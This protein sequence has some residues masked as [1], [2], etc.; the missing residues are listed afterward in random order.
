[1]GLVTMNRR[2]RRIAG[3][4]LC[5]TIAAST[6]GASMAAKESSAELDKYTEEK[7]IVDCLLQGQIRK[8]GTTVYQ[9]PPRP[10]KLPARDCEIRGGDF[11]VFDRSS[12]SASLGHWLTLA[13]QGDVEA[14]IYVGEIFERGMGRE[15]DYERAAE[16][17][18]KAAES[19]HPV[20][21]ISLAQLYEKG[22][23][24]PQDA[25]EAE[26]LYRDAFGAGPTEQVALDPGSIDD[27]AERMQRLETQLA[28]A[29][30]EAAEL[31]QQ[32]AASEQRLAAAQSNLELRLTEEE[33]LQRQLADAQARVSAA[34]GGSSELAAAQQELDHRNRE[35]LN[36][37]QTI[38]SLREEID[39]NEGQIVAYQGEYA[40]ISELETRLQQQTE[41]YEAV[42]TELREARA[43]IAASN[44]RMLEQQA[45]FDAEREAL[46]RDREA[47]EDDDAATLE[48]QEQLRAQLRDRET[49]LAEQSQSLEGMRAQID[50][51]QSESVGLQNQ[52][53]ELQRQN[54]EMA[55]ASNRAA[56]QRRQE[57]QRLRAALEAAQQ[58]VVVL[59]QQDDALLQDMRAQLQRV[60]DEAEGYKQRIR[61]LEDQAPPPTLAGPDIQLIEPVAFN[62][63]N[64]GDPNITITSTEDQLIIGKVIAPAGLLTLLV[65]QEPTEFNENHV[66]Q[67]PIPIEGEA[68]PVRIAAIDNQGRRVEQFFRLVNEAFGTPEPV[69]GP[70]IPD[71]E[72]GEF[73][74]LLIGNE[75]YAELPDLETPKE[76][77]DEIGRILRERYGFNT[78]IIKDG[79]RQE[80]MDSM[81]Q[82]NKT[83]TSK[84]N[85]LI[86][87][88]GHGEYVTNTNRGVWL[89]IDASPSSPANWITNVD[90][91]DY[92]KMIAA[93]QIVV[94][95]DSCY[96]GA[97]TRSA[98]IN[99]RPGL[100]DEE[101]TAHLRRMAQ[102]QA[103]VVLTSGGLAPVLDSA[104]PDS[105]HSIFAAAL[106]EILHENNNV[107]S[108]QD[109]GRTIAAKVS[110]AAERVGYDQ[111]PQY[112]PLNHANHQGGD[113]FFVPDET[114]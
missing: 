38:A 39:R 2:N 101:Y 96:S 58:Q 19:G 57:E 67:A 43:A 92:L 23:G 56:M 61:E 48:Q 65:N 21:Q 107:L 50:A 76:D 52:L 17:Y 78:T 34:E 3:A 105:Q 62:T 40:R 103:R 16:W 24:V 60:R 114:I 9:A 109:L 27:P 71:V 20:A 44:Q 89:P 1:M 74:A 90:I 73:H 10:E 102:I 100:T 53:A 18:R 108:A 32:L 4:C 86:Y 12:Y 30:G 93:K 41:K 31:R 35:L 37:Q 84:D 8:L 97:L 51:Q 104:S 91:N 66:F 113:F 99:L 28:A 15:P 81:Y 106:I 5:V 49:R 94:I 77:V 13:K 59:E 29:Q 82:L 112:A 72:F 80:I 70:V 47:L 6:T 36:Q 45:A 83:L 42:N 98:L 22:L 88:A 87:Y 75:E 111:E 25:G 26:K 7:R 79:S 64:A 11:L 69:P 95:A 46:I 54:D 63:R 14:Q 33:T 110:L 68:T 55:L 85:L